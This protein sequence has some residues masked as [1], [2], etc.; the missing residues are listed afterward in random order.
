MLSAKQGGIKYHF[1]SL[2]YDSTWDWTQVSRTI[3]E[4]SNPLVNMTILLKN[5]FKPPSNKKYFFN[6]FFPQKKTSSFSVG[7]SLNQNKALNQGRTF[8]CWVPKLHE[9]WG[10]SLKKRWQNFI[11]FHIIVKE[12]GKNYIYI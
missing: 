6:D 1:L 3:G 7:L 4:H 11:I 10:S 5:N 8:T 12:K 2:W 9:I